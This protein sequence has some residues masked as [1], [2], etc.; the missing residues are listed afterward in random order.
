MI[1]NIKKPLIV[2]FGVLFSFIGFANTFWGND[3][4]YGL[5]I[6]LISVLFYIPLID[7]F[8]NNLSSKVKT[9]I[10]FFLG[11]FVLWSS[12]GVGELSDKIKIMIE[13]FPY[14]NITGY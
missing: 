6:L 11:F 12:A 5:A 1:K 9:L 8:R 2:S 4:Y 14:T 3:P 7:S 13:N 10:L